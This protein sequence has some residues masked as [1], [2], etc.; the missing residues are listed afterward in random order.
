MTDAVHMTLDDVRTLATEVLLANGMSPENAA[1]IADVV[2][3]AE[4][5]PPATCPPAS[6]SSRGRPRPK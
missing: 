4:S 1:V 6:S 2:T 5:R 3:C